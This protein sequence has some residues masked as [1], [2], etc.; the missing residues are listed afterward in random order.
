MDFYKHCRVNPKY[1]RLQDADSSFT[2]TLTKEKAEAIQAADLAQLEALQDKFYAQD[3]Y[4]LL[5][6]LQ[7]MDAAGKDGT[8]KHVISG[9]NPQGVD[10]HSFKVPSQEELQHDYLWRCQRALPQRGRIGIFNR[11]YY[12]EVLVVRV[13]PELLAAQRLPADVAAD[14]DIWKRRYEDIAAFERHLQRNG[15]RVVKFFLHLSKEEQ[16]QRLL[17]RIDS[18]DKNWKVSR[19]DYAERKY[20]D[21]YQQ[22]YQ[23]MLRATSTDHAPWYVIAAD[24]KWFGRTAVSSI[25]VRTLEALAPAYPSVSEAPRRELIEVRG[26]LVAEGA[27]RR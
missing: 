16:R 10:V 24:H 11:S 12:E 7:G 5:V 26:L 18:G 25:L 23:E 19:S 17:A 22:A 2:G 15:V 3:R 14:P 21:R 27:T 13:H 6:V 20:W 9:V 4:A 8:I 1:F